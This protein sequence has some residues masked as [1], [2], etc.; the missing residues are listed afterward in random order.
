MPKSCPSTNRAARAISKPSR[1]VPIGE[2]AYIDPYDE[3]GMAA[4]LRDP[5]EH[6]LYRARA[7]TELRQGRVANFQI[8]RQKI[9]GFIDSIRHQ[10]PASAVGQ[11]CGM[12]KADNL[13]VD[14]SGNVI[15]CQNV[16]AAATAPN[17]ESHKIGHLSNLSNVAMKTATHWRQRRDCAAC[18]VLQLCQGSSMFLDGLLWEAGCDSAYSDNVPLFAAAIEFL[19]G[20]T[21]YYIEGDFRGERKD[22]FGKVREVP[23]AQ[24]KRVIAIHAVPV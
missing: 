15:T 18:P 24:K 3:G 16:S 21:P 22:L 8:A 2:G 19:T 1:S 23:E 10:R 12:D 11:K 6:L 4:V 13:A 7:F 17:G 5:P 20:Y 14:L 9:Q